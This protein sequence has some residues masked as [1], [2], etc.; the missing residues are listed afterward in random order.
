MNPLFFL[1]ASNF[2]PESIGLII[3]GGILFAFSLIHTELASVLS[4]PVFLLLFAA[5]FAV[6]AGINMLMA[7]T[8]F[9]W[10]GN[11]R[12]PEIFDSIMTF[13]KYPVTIF[14]K[15]IKGIATFLIPVGMI[16]YFPATALLGRLEPS[17]LFALIPCFLFM[18]FGIWLYLRMV[19]LY[20]GAGG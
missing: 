6:M 2:D 9:K 19:K 12:I 20:E 8:S 5:G 10:V 18:I 16:G 17:A 4:I 7:A 14:P 13:G 11:S 3:G 15:T 1:I